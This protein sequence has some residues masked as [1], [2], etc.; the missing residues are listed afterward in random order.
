MSWSGGHH[1]AARAG[2]VSVA[3]G[4][5][6]GAAAKADG[7]TAPELGSELGFLVSLPSS[8]QV[9]DLLPGLAL[10]ACGVVDSSN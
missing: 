8:G 7:A 9:N 5:N 4:W 10:G 1:A 6:V 3:R 2:A